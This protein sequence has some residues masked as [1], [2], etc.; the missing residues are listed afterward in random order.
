MVSGSPTTTPLATTSHATHTTVSFPRS[1]SPMLSRRCHHNNHHEQRLQPH[2]VNTPACR[3]LHQLCHSST[4]HTTAPRTLSRR[5]GSS[6]NNATPPNTSNTSVY[7][8]ASGGVLQLGQFVQPNDLATAWQD[9]ILPGCLS[10]W[11]ALSEQLAAADSSS[12]AP[13]RCGV[14]QGVDVQLIEHVLLQ[15]DAL[16]GTCQQVRCM[17]HLW[18]AVCEQ[19]HLHVCQSALSSHALSPLLLPHM[20]TPRRC[21]WCVAC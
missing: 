12:Q 18:G 2:S 1:L 8:A 20:R 7:P 5:R 15:L 9:D 4:R 19:E 10:T 21:C 3:A 17:Q 13:A 16:L 11:Q 6:S 14:S